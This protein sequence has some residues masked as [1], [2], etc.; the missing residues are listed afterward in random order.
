[1][2][3]RVISHLLTAPVFEMHT[4]WSILIR[5]QFMCTMMTTHVLLV[6]NLGREMIIR[7]CEAVILEGGITM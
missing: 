6:I 7:T 3:R 2:G 1:M 4:N 5:A